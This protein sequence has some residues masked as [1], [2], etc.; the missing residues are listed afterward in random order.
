MGVT[1]VYRNYLIEGS[2]FEFAFKCKTI[3]DLTKFSLK[4]FT[5]K[6]AKIKFD[7]PEQK[8][9]QFDFTIHALK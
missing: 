9:P 3:N 5:W 2:N 6:A 1:F 7:D 4:I 8:V